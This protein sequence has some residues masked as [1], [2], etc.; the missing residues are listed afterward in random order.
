MITSDLYTPTDIKKVRELLLAEQDGKDKL[1]GIPIPL[2]SQVL[3]H[4]HDEQ[5]F[6]RGVLHR[7]C[8]SALGRIENLWTRELS[9]W[10]PGTLSQFL[11]QAADYLELEV[12]KRYRHSNWQKKIKTNFN[13]L[14]AR[15][16]NDV[17]AHFGSQLGSN[18]KQRK[19]LFRSLVMQRELGYNKIL[20]V[21]KDIQ[22]EG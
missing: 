4:A 18:P 3:D 15:Q 2:K 5:Q 19:E 16:Q 8:N 14:S 7:N 21:I 17:L 12:D 11:R 1:T 22:N 20:S 6:V 10:Y 13:K 9:W